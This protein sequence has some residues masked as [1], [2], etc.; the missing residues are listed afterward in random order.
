MANLETLTTKATTENLSTALDL[1]KVLRAELKNV[2]QQVDQFLANPTIEQL[3][4]IIDTLSLE[5]PQIQVDQKME[6]L[7]NLDPIA[8]LEILLNSLAKADKQKQTRE[9]DNEISNKIKQRMD[10]Q[11]REYYLREKMRT[12][13]E[14]L[15]EGDDADYNIIQKY[16]ERLENEPFPRNI[17]ERILASIN[18][19]DTIQASSPESNVE[20]NYID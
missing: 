17:K 6:L 16:R 15:G 7:K 18:K 3:S 12:I 13:K 10:Q 1:I 11:Q 8:R 9:V 4:F 14:E 19:L 20:R 5:L 2:P